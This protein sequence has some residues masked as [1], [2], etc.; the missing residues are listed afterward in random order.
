[1]S[2]APLPHRAAALPQCGGTAYRRNSLLVNHPQT[3]GDVA[4]HLTLSVAIKSR[5]LYQFANTSGKAPRS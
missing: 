5:H 2:M 1:L 3:G 4:R